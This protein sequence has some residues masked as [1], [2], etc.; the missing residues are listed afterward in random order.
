[1]YNDA[2]LAF[3]FIADL[4]LRRGACNARVERSEKR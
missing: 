4:L 1:M 3:L 2:A